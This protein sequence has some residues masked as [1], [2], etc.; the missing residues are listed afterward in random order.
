MGTR[1]GR[2]LSTPSRRSLPRACGFLGLLIGAV[3]TATAPVAAQVTDTAAVDS[4]RVDSLAAAQDTAGVPQDT[5]VAPPPLMPAFPVPRATDWAAGVW[6]WDRNALLAEAVLTLGELLARIPGVAVLR[7]GMFIQ[8]SPV[9]TFG[10]TG[11]RFEIEL[12]GFVLDP[13]SAGVFDIARLELAQFNS[14]EVIRRAD[15]VRVRL[16]SVQ[17]EDARAYSRIEAGIGEPD[18]NMFRGMLLVPKVIVGPFGFAVDRLDTDGLGANEPADLFTTWLKWGWLSETRGLQL[19]LRN[20]TVDREPDSP[21]PGSQSRLDV[22]LRARNVFAPGLIGEA[23]AGRSS[24]REEAL[25]TFDVLPPDIERPGPLERQSW[26]YGARAAFD[27]DPLRAEGAVRFRTEEA[28]PS[29]QADFDAE[30]RIL[31]YGRV[32]GSITQTTWESGAAAFG[33]AGRAEVGP[34][35][36]LRAFAELSGGRRGAPVYRPT[37]TLPHAISSRETRRVGGDFTFRRLRVGGAMLRVAT[38]SVPAFGLPFDTAFT[39]FPGGEATGWE[40]TGSV[41][42]LWSWLSAEGWFQRWTS[43]TTWAYLPGESGRLALVIHSLPL[44][45]GNLEILARGEIEHHGAMLAPP[46]PL[47]E[48]DP[49][50]AVSPVR[51]VINGYLMIRIIDVTIFGRLEDWTGRN[52]EFLPGRPIRGP[53]LVYGV[54]WHFWN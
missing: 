47:D 43:G 44:E 4:V 29:M 38:D 39:W 52:A 6:H 18:A 48:D 54:K 37:A 2:G 36:G 20:A 31:R 45:S 3:A 30:A 16:R 22:V 14:V 5:V 19:E 40:V 53:R 34:I 25:D 24:I 13:L 17:P 35:A 42:L 50:L 41:P 1:P 12:D 26:Q 51:T 33:W 23:F 10:G 32:G 15:L 8:P 46:L 27:R 7:S 11:P 49:G 21:W 9:S 28:L